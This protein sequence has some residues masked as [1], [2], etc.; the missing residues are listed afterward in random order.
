MTAQILKSPK[1]SEESNLVELE[2]V[3]KKSIKYH[4][5]SHIRAGRATYSNFK[6]V[7]KLGRRLEAYRIYGV[8]MRVQTDVVI[9]SEHDQRDMSTAYTAPSGVPIEACLTSSSVA[10]CRPGATVHSQSATGASSRATASKTAT[11]P[12]FLRRAASAEVHGHQYFFT[13]LSKV[14]VI[15]TV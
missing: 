10:R 11:S 12:T 2:L 8:F 13:L 5:I 1:I 15:Y 9:R 7:Y 3:I 4:D 14:N 6:A